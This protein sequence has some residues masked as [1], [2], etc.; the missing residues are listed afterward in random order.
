M[1]REQILSLGRALAAYL[2]RF[3]DC[4]VRA[5]PRSHLADYVRGQLSDLPR[6]SV[7]PLAHSAGLCPRTLQEFLNTDQWD[8]ERLRDQL[9]R[10]VTTEHADANAIGIIDD[11]GHPKK[12]KHTACVARQYCG[13]TGKI[14]NC[15]NT[16][17][18]S[19]AS[20]DLRFRTMLDSTPYLPEE[21]WDDP[22]RRRVAGIPDE[23]VYRPKYE[24]ALEQI[25][26]A[27]G[28]GLSFGWIVADEW[29]GQK[30]VFLTALQQRRLRFVVEIPCNFSGW[31]SKPSSWRQ[32]LSA[33]NLCRLFPQMTQQPW[34]RL[35]VKTT[36]KGPVVWEIKVAPFWWRH[37]RAVIGPHW[38]LHARNLLDPN[39][40]KY[41]LSN[42]APGTPLE[43]LVHVAFGR[44]PIE[45]CLEDEKSELGLSH[46]EV[47]KYQALQRHLLITQISHLFLAQQT[48]R[49]RGEK[50]GDHFMP[51][52]QRSRRT[53][54][55]AAVFA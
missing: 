12:G 27:L 11:S 2:D 18:L 24:I 34:L 33:S 6:K 13:N 1:T 46:F 41:F 54:R 4:F 31:F 44:W 35:H 53:R 52:S 40:E 25:D 38:L 29:Y 32:P 20:Y 42:A 16:V 39:E 51:G 30:P 9:Q 5:E 55:H 14:D 26:R 43:V 15:V 23:V 47:R 50:S 19:Y 48:K 17:H 49:L 37:G 7:Q 8:H 21:G 3:A 22:K 28:N 36:E 10:I 45:R